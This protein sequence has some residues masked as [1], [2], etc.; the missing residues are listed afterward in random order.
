LLRRRP[1]EGAIEFGSRSERSLANERSYVVRILTRSFTRNFGDLLYAAIFRGRARGFGVFGSCLRRGWIS[2]RLF[3][4]AL[5]KTLNRR[6]I[7]GG[8]RETFHVR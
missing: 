7:W 8:W 1:V 4:P 5:T 6:G 2:F 3:E